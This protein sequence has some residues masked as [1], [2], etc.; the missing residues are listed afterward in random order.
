[1]ITKRFFKT[2]DEVEVKFHVEAEGAE[3]VQVVCDA[4]DWEPVAMKA[5]KKGGFKASLRFPL[6]TSVQFRYLVDGA[7]WLNDETADSYIINEFG[8]QN[9][10]V[11]T[12]KS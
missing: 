8:G 9:A 12:I 11:S 10:V 3:Q 4:R 5:L 6:D 1:M 2:K 7:T